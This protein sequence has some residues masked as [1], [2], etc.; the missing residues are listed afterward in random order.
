MT[1]NQ[2]KAFN[3]YLRSPARG[4]QWLG[5]RLG[6]VAFALLVLWA[7]CWRVD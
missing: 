5:N 6:E 1:I 7:I 2:R 4:K 3:A